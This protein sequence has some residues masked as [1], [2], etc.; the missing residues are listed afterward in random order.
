MGA[1]LVA[2]FFPGIFNKSNWLLTFQ[3]CL[4]QFYEV[5][6]SILMYGI[7]GVEGIYIEKKQH[8]C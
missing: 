5:A 6:I 3:D 2:H 7:S 8:P 1:D 4:E